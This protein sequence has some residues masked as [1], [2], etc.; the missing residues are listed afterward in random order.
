MVVLHMRWQQ[1][2][3][4]D[5]FHDY[6]QGVARMESRLTDILNELEILLGSGYVPLPLA[7]GRRRYRI[8]RSLGEAYIIRHTVL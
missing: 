4:G 8:A 5:A 1:E 6:Y 7:D 2:E 3:E